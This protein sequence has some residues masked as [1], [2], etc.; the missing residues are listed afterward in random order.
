MLI[1]CNTDNDLTSSVSSPLESILTNT[2]ACTK[3]HS[4]QIYHEKS[5]RVEIQR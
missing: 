2:E 5:T 1:S 4:L 3:S